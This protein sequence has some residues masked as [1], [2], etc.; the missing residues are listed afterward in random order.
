MRKMTKQDWIVV[1]I[2]A[3]LVGAVWLVAR[4]PLL[5]RSDPVSPTRADMYTLA[6]VIDLYNVDNDISPPSL[7]VL[8]ATG[9]AFD[10]PYLRPTD[11]LTD[12]WGVEIRYRNLTN[13]YELVS[14]GPDHRFGTA[15]DVVMKRK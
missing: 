3:V 1:L 8:K 2:A 6:T 13:S 7:D 10:K 14:A 15:D 12:G 11:R 5:R 9:K 4:V